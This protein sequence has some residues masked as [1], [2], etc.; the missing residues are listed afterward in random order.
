MVSCH[1]LSDIKALA[2]EWELL[3]SVSPHHFF[4][5]WSW[6]SAWLVSYN[7][8]VSVLRVHNGSELIG[9]A[10]IVK[11]TQKRHGVLNSKV[12]MIHQTGNAAEDQ[13]WIEYNGFLF[14]Q[15]YVKEAYTASM[16]FLLHRFPGWDEIVIGAVPN[17]V[18]E[19]LEHDKKLY[20]HD[21]WEA[22]TYGIDLLELREGNKNYLSTL[23]RNT[24]YQIRRSGKRYASR[25]DVV[26]QQASTVGQALQFF[27]E[28]S[29]LHIARWGE[30]ESGFTNPAFLKFH[31]ALIQGSWSKGQVDLCRV[32]VAGQAIAY[33]YNFTYNRRVYFYLS[34]LVSEDDKA[35][36]PGL[37]GHSLCIQRY[38]EKDMDYYDFM[39]GEA[40]YKQSLGRESIPIF[41]V[42]LQ[43]D[44]IKFRLER[45]ARLIK[46]KISQSKQGL[47]SD[48]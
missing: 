31:E 9:L 40:R 42:S 37:L 2:V 19:R 26:M 27:R 28:I 44:L 5:S 18:V 47:F 15:S 4:L 23:S 48:D 13:I 38:I 25:G 20:R 36:K 3:A 11:T 43:K 12:L 32:D 6:I 30:V 22:P 29:P 33:F 10:L 39:G 45:S 41:Q 24:R 8:D 21:L 7:P 34:G 14:K 46:H 35:L 17:C 16:E 1:K